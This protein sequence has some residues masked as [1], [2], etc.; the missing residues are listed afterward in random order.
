MRID[1]SKLEEAVNLQ[2]SH[3]RPSLDLLLAATDTDP[4][5]L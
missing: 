1:P 2:L 5:V 3:P 4:E